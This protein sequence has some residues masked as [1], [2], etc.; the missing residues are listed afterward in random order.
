MPNNRRAQQLSDEVK[1]TTLCKHP[2][3]ETHPRCVAQPSVATT[4][5]TQIAI[6]G[7]IGNMITTSKDAAN[8]KLP[9]SA[10][11][12]ERPDQ[13][14]KSTSTSFGFVMVVLFLVFEY[15]RPQDKLG[16]IG[17]LHPNWIITSLMVISWFKSRGLHMAASPQTSHMLLLL[18]LLAL[19]VPFAVNNFKAFW[20]TES[21]L[22]FFPFVISCILFIDTFHRLRVFMKCWIFLML[23]IALNGIL[24]L[25][26]AGSSFL[27]DENDFSLL[28]NMMLPF[29]FCFFIYE[30]QM[31]AKSLYLIASLLCVAS[32]VV[33]ASRGGFVGLVAVLFVIWLAS[34][35]KVLSLVLVG[36]LASAI[37]TVAD[38]SYWK[39]VESISDPKESTAKQRLDSWQAGW[40]MFKDNPLGVG[41][42]NFAV[43]FPEYQ[44][45]SFQR[46]MWGREAH[47]LW[48]TLLPELGIP[49][50]LLYLSLLRAN[51]RDLRYLRNLSTASDTHRFAYF[52]SLAFMAS[53]VGYFASGTFLSVLYYPHYWYLTAMIV[54]TRKIIDSTYTSKSGARSRRGRNASVVT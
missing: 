38:E 49:G 29:S 7:R 19:H 20:L 39:D 48:L 16:I 47:S 2:Q 12:V 30:S 1:T 43:R 22:L 21:F 42:A 31:K 45:A 13:E 33:S 23:Y 25:G 54:V 4:A 46:G 34:P 50:A 11:R 41:P 26:V 28:M 17:A 36:A 32:T 18:L 10:V 14:G 37:Y 51:V 8:G 24:G 40:D 52:L 6:T 44:P 9:A 15:G 35:R 5:V 3:L 27:S 53:L